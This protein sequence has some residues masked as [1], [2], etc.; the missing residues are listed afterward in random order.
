MKKR[1]YLDY[2]ATTPCD[3]R[4][5]KAMLPFFYDKFGNSSSSHYFG[6]QAHEALEASRRLIAGV[7]KVQPEEIIFTA[8]ATE[9]N[10]LV[11]KGVAFANQSKGRH[12][13]ISAVE[14][15]CVLKSALWLVKQ[16]F[17]VE[18]IPV[19]KVGLVN[20]E[21]VAKLLR[22]ETI[23]VSVIHANNEIGT[24]EP[25]EK[26]GEICHQKNVLFHTDASQSFAKIPLNL[27]KLKVDLLTASSHKIYG[28]KGAALIYLRKGVK[29]EPLLHG[30]GHEQGWRS[31]TVNVP[32][33]V[34]FAKAV[35]IYEKT[36]DKE[37]KRLKQLKTILIKGVL[38][39]INFSYLNGSEEN[40]L[41]NI[42]SFRFLGVEGE[43]IVMRLDMKGVA[44]ASGSACSSQ[45]LTPSHVL[46][47]CGLKPA[48]IHGTVR[49][50]LGRWTTKEEINYVLQVL[51]EIIKSLRKISPFKINR[52][53][54]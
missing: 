37:L 3:P 53:N 2:A 39:K 26:I 11:L 44:V 46:T 25:I 47:A 42:V 4:V 43:S 21:S 51:P 40:S 13:L 35:E 5:I 45:T 23:L 22:K 36:R 1:I 20:P 9:S 24:I 52:I 54:Y 32:A 38:K 10:N 7:L 48:E 6:R 14:H 18:Q 28:P 31:S 49:F 8:S 41:P 16:G 29:L 27:E 50:S 17:Q 12:I 33:I 15:D 19:N 30:G 34:G